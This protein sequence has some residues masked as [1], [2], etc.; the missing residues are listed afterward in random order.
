MTTCTHRAEIRLQAAVLY[1]LSGGDNPIVIKLI[2]K[3]AP[4]LREIINGFE[5]K[6]NRLPTADEIIWIVGEHHKLDPHCV[7]RLLTDI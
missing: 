1:E 5:I 2:D 6:E 4:E 7:N 3:L